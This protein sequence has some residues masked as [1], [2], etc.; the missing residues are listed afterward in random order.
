M[1]QEPYA[2]AR[3][4]FVV[5]DSGSSHRG[6]TSVD[7]TRAKWPNVTLVHVPVHAS[8]LNQVLVFS[9]LQRKVLSPNDLVDLDALAERIACFERR[10]NE[11]AQP[12]NWNFT[13]CHLKLF[14]D[15]LHAH[16]DAAGQLA[17]A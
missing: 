1:A 10:F 11:K 17:A 12:F 7:R 9:I 2:S 4:V 8:C 13:R 15:K 16:E 5:C 3:T 14:L 6:Q